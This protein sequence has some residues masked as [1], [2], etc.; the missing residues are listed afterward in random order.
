[1]DMK[2]MKPGESRPVVHENQRIGIALRPTAG[3]AR[4][5]FVSPGHRVDVAYSEQL[6]RLFLTGRR[7]PEPI[8]WADRLS[9]RKESC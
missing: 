2:D 3:S 7:L 6:V 9:K 4:P 5:I 8:Y 1:V